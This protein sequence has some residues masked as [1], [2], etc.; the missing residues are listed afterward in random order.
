MLPD[1]LVADHLEAQ[2]L[3]RLLPD[4]D[5][6]PGRPYNSSTCPIGI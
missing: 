6:P 2:R 4:F 3:V 5:F 1:Y